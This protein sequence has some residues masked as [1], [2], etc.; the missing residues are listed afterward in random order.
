MVGPGSAGAPEGCP[1]TEWPL[2]HAYGAAA[3][4]T[5]GELGLGP[6]VP[7][8]GCGAQGL[9]APGPLLCGAYGSAV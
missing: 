3:V 5:R 7:G 4:G 1:G 6:N 9:A 2:L 8:G